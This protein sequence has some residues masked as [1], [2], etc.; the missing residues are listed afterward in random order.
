MALGKPLIVSNLGGL[1]ELVENE[2]NGYIYTDLAESINKMISLDQKEYSKLCENSL[3][4]AKEWF[5]ANKYVE[6]LIYEKS[7]NSNQN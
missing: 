3:L 6:E 7:S 5:N 4:K 1:P 2:K